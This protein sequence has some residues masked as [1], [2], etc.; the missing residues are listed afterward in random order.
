MRRMITRRTLLGML[1]GLGLMAAGGVGRG[2]TGPMLTRAIPGTGEQL[3]VI[4]MGSWITFD[5]GVNPARRATRADVLRTF[6]DAGGAVI[7]SSPM[8]G[9]S[10]AVIGWCLRHIGG[11]HAPFAATKVWTQGRWMGQQ[12]MRR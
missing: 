12:Q 6:F 8:Y 4:G 7:D 3:P 10:E 11:A 2:A 9:S 1:G 5:V